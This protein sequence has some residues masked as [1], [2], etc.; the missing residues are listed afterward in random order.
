MREHEGVMV[1][2]AIGIVLGL[3]AYAAGQGIGLAA[4]I[5]YSGLCLASV[6]Y[7]LTH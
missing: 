4:V 3:V 1:Y 2:S 5:F 6:L 7:Q